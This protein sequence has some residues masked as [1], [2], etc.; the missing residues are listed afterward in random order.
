MF[1]TT[2]ISAVLALTSMFHIEAKDTVA[3]RA[4]ADSVQV[5]TKADTVK[6]RVPVV[7]ISTN[8]P[9]DITWV[10]GYGVTSIPSFSLEVYPSGWKHFT[11]GADVEWP[12]WKHWDTHR[13]MQ[14]NNITLWT[15]RYFH[16][17]AYEESPKGLYLL[18]N[19]NAARFGIGFDDKGWQGEGLGASLGVGY[20]HGFGKSRFW[21][22][23][24][25]AAGFFYSRYDPYVYGK[26][27]TGWYY[28]DYRGNIADFV[29]RRMALWWFGPTRVYFSVGFDF[30]KKVKK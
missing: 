11:L 12:M 6:L 28:Y 19:A 18:A 29:P 9:Y 3:V 20:K 23:T 26:D 7:G 27:G 21:F 24:G 8:I 4:G 5:V 1:L 17:R 2:L 30:C 13:F 22:D 25:I 10:P 16:T 14:V 15:R